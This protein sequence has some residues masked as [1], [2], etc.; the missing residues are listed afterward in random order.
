MDSVK[1]TSIILNAPEQ[2][3]DPSGAGPRC[4]PGIEGCD[5]AFKAAYA[6]PHYGTNSIADRSGGMMSL[7]N[8]ASRTW[9]VSLLG[10]ALGAPRG[11]RRRPELPSGKKITT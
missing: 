7:S 11:E 2:G 6:R 1:D 5:L 10:A 4:P 8:P 3:Q 9:D